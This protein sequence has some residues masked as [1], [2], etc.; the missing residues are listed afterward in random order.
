[1]PAL[2]DTFT[3]S[4]GVAIPKI[5]FGTWQIPDGPEA[6]DATTAA[7]EAGYRHIDTARAYGNEASVARAL[8]D[9]GVPRDEVFITT[10]LPAEVK[11]YEGAKASF[12]TTMAALELDH[13]DL[14]L[15]HAPWPWQDMGSDHREG[16]IAAWKAMEEI[17]EA[18][19]SRAIGVSNF[20]VADLESLIAATDV[21]PHANQIRWFVGNTQDETTAYCKE[22]GILVEGYSPLATGGLLDNSDIGEIAAKYDK[23]VAQLCIRYLLEKDV[24]PLPK[25]TT[26]SR[27]VENAD[28]DFEISSEDLA[29]LDSLVDTES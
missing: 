7:L 15:I 29:H 24:L 21:V 28:V 14:Y 4:N 8:R 22:H 12:E 23:S 17:L 13:V 19:R 3:L 27:I 20:Q 18:G 9:S 16:N 11:D 5:G 1:M 25:S 6:Y 2:T 26:P 10:K